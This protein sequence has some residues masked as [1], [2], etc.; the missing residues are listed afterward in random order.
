MLR[1][2]LCFQVSKRGCHT[3]NAAASCRKSYIVENETHVRTYTINQNNPISQSIISWLRTH[4]AALMTN[5]GGMGAS[6]QTNCNLATTPPP[7]PPPPPPGKFET[8]SSITCS[9]CGIRVEKWHGKFLSPSR[10]KEESAT[11][12]F[13]GFFVDPLNSAFYGFLCSHARVAGRA[14]SCETQTWSENTASAR[15]ALM[16]TNT[17]PHLPSLLRYRYCAISRIHPQNRS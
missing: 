11:K 16:L 2:L 13:R 15:Q 10:S 7:S 12:M 9:S 4:H 14:A 3:R 17:T 1:K 5:N 8:A 6:L